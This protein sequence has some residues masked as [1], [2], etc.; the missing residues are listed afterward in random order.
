MPL[1]N[2]LYE[3]ESGALIWHAMPLLLGALCV[4]AIANR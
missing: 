1:A 3:E 2:L 4:L